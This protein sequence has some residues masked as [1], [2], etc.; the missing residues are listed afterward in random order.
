VEER[1]YSLFNRV[2]MAGPAFAHHE[3]E[4][5]R[6]SAGAVGA[7]VRSRTE[8]PRDDWPYLYLARRGISS[9]Y[10][11]LMAI[12]A[13]LGVLSVA[14]ASPELRSS[15]RARSV[16]G[17][18]FLFGLAFLLLE[19]RS[20]TEMTLVWGATWLTSAVVFA[21]ILTM[22]LLATLVAQRRPLS[23]R[24]SMTGLV[25]LLLL[26]YALPTQLLLVSSPALRLGLSV[27]FVGGPIFFAASCFALLFRARP[28]AG[29][30]FGWNLLGAVAGGL[31]EFLSMAVG[32]KALLIVATAAYLAA[33]LVHSRQTSR[34]AVTTSPTATTG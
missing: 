24:A 22:I 33:A 29:V 7:V 34:S 25:A 32:L 20:V 23:Y 3:G 1:S 19:T 5:R 8:L 18:M 12:F 31:L 11:T 28:Q 2:Y 13:G 17:E 15:L 26:V 16:D 4:Q 14:A 6:T 27:A 10:A 30:A 9:F 21:A